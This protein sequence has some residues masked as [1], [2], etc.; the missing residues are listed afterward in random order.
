MKAKYTIIGLFVI[1]LISISF[2]LYSKTKNEWKKIDNLSNQELSNI[3]SLAKLYGYSRYFYPNQQVLKEIDYIDWY[4]FLV[5]ASNKVIDSETET[6]FRNKILKIFTPIVPELSFDTPNDSKSVSAHVNE[7][8]AWEHYGIGI[9]LYNNIFHSDIISYNAKQRINLPTPDSMYSLPL[10]GNMNAYMPL[11]ISYQHSQP[12]DKLNQLKKDI[13]KIKFKLATESFL[14]LAFGKPEKRFAFLQDYHFRMADIIV[15]WNIIRHFYPYFEEDGLNIKW[16]DVLKTSLINAVKCKDQFEYYDVVNNML[17]YV[18][19]SHISVNK[20]GYVGGIAAMVL[21]YYFPDIKLD[22]CED[23]IYLR[24]VPDTLTDKLS[25]GDVLVSVNDIPIDK[26]IEKKWD[27]VS[28]STKQGKYEALLRERL[29][30]G[31]TK[32]SLLR[33][34]FKK[35]NNESEFVRLFANYNDDIIYKEEYP[36]FIKR[37]D[38][39]IYHINLTHKGPDATY[40]VFK[41]YIEEFKNAKGIILDIRGYP[42]Y[43]VTDSI[44]PHFYVDSIRWGDFGRPIYYYPN[45]EKVIYDRGVEY[46]P[47]TS[48]YINTPVSVLINHKAMSYAETII[49]ILK[50]NK[51]GTLIGEPTIGTNGDVGILNLPVYAFNMSIIKDFSG[52]HGKGIFPDITVK[53]TLESIQNNKDNILETAIKHIYELDTNNK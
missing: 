18:H 4:R 48:D 38:N 31:F 52:Y 45:Q 47:K 25:I 16:D 41:E 28:A 43:N 46:L 34:E 10:N 8:Y 19:D 51:I 7:S 13:K 37:L 3:G 49:E 50:R 30:G 9:R 40:S 5:F 32:D 11:S 21:Q 44:I 2:N 22:W 12:S 36:Y 14:K 15:R 27:L 17:S 1:F 33:L 42:D 29:L 20:G 6:E 39:N 53:R 24:E 23:K 26:L 35:I